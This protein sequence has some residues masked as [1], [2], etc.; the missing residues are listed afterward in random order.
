M[1]VI[2]GS[3][4]RCFV[5]DNNRRRRREGLGVCDDVLKNHPNSMNCGTNTIVLLDA[6]LWVFTK[7]KI[8]EKKRTIRIKPLFPTLPRS[9]MIDWNEEEIQHE[10]NLYLGYLGWVKRCRMRTS[11][12]SF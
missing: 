2:L 5:L 4:P 1:Q 11:N 9:T 12:N 6:C 10:R 3:D 8:K 7:N